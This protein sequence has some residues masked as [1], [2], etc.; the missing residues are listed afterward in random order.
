M[1]ELSVELRQI[2]WSPKRPRATKVRGP[3]P[4]AARKS[5]SI[6]GFRSVCVC[7]GWGCEFKRPGLVLSAGR[8]PG[9]GAGCPAAAHWP[10]NRSGSTPAD[11]WTQKTGQAN[12]WLYLENDKGKGA[13]DRGAFT[14][15]HAR[16]T[17]VRAPSMTAR[18][19][20]AYS[21]TFFALS[22]SSYRRSTH[23]GAC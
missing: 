9:G 19:W 22:A 1:S 16:N 3:G 11:R 17:A 21:G 14:C 5:R 15:P 10:R 13:D 2:S 12:G 6:I 8:S 23:P 4:Q 18:R 7:G 20:S